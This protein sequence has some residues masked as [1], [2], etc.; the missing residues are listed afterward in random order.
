M[1]EEVVVEAAPEVPAAS[2]KEAAP[3]EID[4]SLLT[5]VK[6]RAKQPQQPDPSE[7]NVPGRA[8]MTTGSTSL[9]TLTLHPSEMPS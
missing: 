9:Q 6:G 5:I 7:R 3:I 1:A 2:T 8:L 4:E